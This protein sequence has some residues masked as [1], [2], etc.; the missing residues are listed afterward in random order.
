M[1][2][3]EKIGSATGVRIELHNKPLLIM[4]AKKEF[5]MCGYLD[6]RISTFCGNG[7]LEIARQFRDTETQSVSRVL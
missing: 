2:H 3:T 5:I 1:I 7:V 6:T 4:V